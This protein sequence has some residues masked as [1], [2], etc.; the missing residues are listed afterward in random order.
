[1]KSKNG[2]Y[3]LFVQMCAKFPSN[4]AI[5]EYSNGRYNTYSYSELY[6]VCEYIY[7]NLQQLHCTKGVIGILSDRN[8][9]VPCVIAAAHKYTT[10]FMFLDPS[11]DITSITNKI[12][13]S[14]IIEIKSC[15]SYH[16][17][18]LLGQCPDISVAVFELKI[19]F[20]NLNTRN[21]ATHSNLH[22][23]ICSTSGS[24]GEP[25]LIQ[26]PIQCIEPNVKDLTKL[27]EITQN[28][29]IYFSTPLT[30]DPSMIEIQLAYMNG[31]SL[32]IAPENLD[33]MF[34]EKESLS[35][36]V[37]FWQTTP[38]KLFQHSIVDM[39]EK[40]LSA[41]STLRCL[42]LGGE[43]LSGISR[44]KQSKSSVNKTRVFALYGVTEMS[45]WASVAELDLDK[46][47]SDREVPLGKC[48][49]ETQINIEPIAKHSNIGR[50]ILSSESRRCAV[51]NES[52]SNQEV[53]LK[54]V[55]TGDLAEVHNGTMYFRGRKDDVI[56]RFGHK[57]DLKLIESTA[58]HSPLVKSCSCIWLPKPTLLVVYY[59]SDTLTT[60]ELSNFLKS[61]LNDKHWPDKVIRIENLPLNPHG[62]VSKQTLNTLFNQRLLAHSSLTEDCKS[63]FIKELKC[64]LDSC[65]SYDEI[66]DK[67]FYSIGGTSFMAVAMCNR[68]SQTYPSFAKSALPLLLSH[69]NTIYTVVQEVDKCILDVVKKPKRKI[70][71]TRCK[72]LDGET[73]SIKKSNL[74]VTTDNQTSIITA[75]RMTE[76][77]FSMSVEWSYDTGKCVD[78]SPELFHIDSKVYI[79]VSS[80]SGKIV[81]LDSKSGEV[82]G[83]ITE[84]SRVEASVYCHQPP[85]GVPPYGV[86]G[87]Y[88][89]TIV[90]FRLEN[91]TEMW[92]RN[93]KHRIKSKA[94]FCNGTLYVATYEGVIWLIDISTGAIKSSVAVSEHPISAD[95]V[96][97]GNK[98]VLFGTL[99]GECGCLDST[100]N[101][102][103]WRDTLGSPIF[104]NP[105][106][107]DED[108]YVIFTDV[109]GCIHCRTV[110]KGVKV[111]EYN[112]A[113]G[114]IFSSMYLR[115]LSNVKWQISFGCHDKKVYSILVDRLLPRLLWSTDMPSQVFATP[116]AINEDVFLA[117]ASNGCLCVMEARSG[118]ILLKY[119]LPNETFSSPVVYSN[120][121]YIGCR[122]DNV[123]SLK[124]DLNSIENP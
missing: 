69:K 44:L 30:F 5:R 71:R 34:P 107:Y 38:S 43:S 49:S 26:V 14:S 19:N 86:V 121:V 60:R 11:Q 15:K 66:K 114:N 12:Q 35:H 74:T 50:I 36:S 106:V 64:T 91:G 17:S 63:Q 58:L 61:K 51:L 90:C 53:I 25:K 54:N 52:N 1:M 115:K 117:A 81:I 56:K 93:V 123:Y 40:I 42:A 70:K 80:H 101:T 104:S 85:E 75:D 29:V 55:D 95:L 47:D 59:V 9:I 103:K 41:S 87:T 83:L 120:S 76:V 65:I 113:K 88:D 68:M 37:T 2:Y 6:G 99:K 16:D 73:V 84:S 33:I 79:V 8:M 122:D 112:G 39:S 22:S 92:K 111:W 97:A 32:L 18:K 118:A 82:Q 48:L 78:A 119:R 3:D 24:T 4:I 89:G 98:Y 116:C 7:Q 124:L 27:F 67:D 13:F 110:D 105:V 46:I 96:C 94:T 102:I 72:T 23:F 109:S 28:D 10:S 21:S 108:K 100:D 57:V 31:A 45:C 77:P 62:K 20:Y